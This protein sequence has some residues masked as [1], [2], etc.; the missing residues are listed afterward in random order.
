MS[1]VTAVKPED[2]YQIND[3]NLWYGEHHALKNINL[4]IPE[5]EIT[6]I[7]GPSGCGKSTFIKTLNL[8]INMVPNVK[9]TGEISY[10]GT[11]VLNSK[12]DLVELRKKVGMVFQ[13]GNPFPQSIFD[14]VAY[15]PR[16]HGLKNK[17][18]LNER[19]EK[20]LV[21]VALWDEVKD[22][23]HSQALGLSGG[24]QQ[25]LCIARALATNPDVLLMDEPTSALD[26]V[27]TLKIEELMLKLKEKYTIAI[28]THNMQQ[29]SRISDQTAFFLMGE[30]IECNDTV[31]MFSSPDDHRTK[32]YITGRFG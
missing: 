6:A 28:V 19:V 1:A 14:N 22:R 25:R 24:Q 3:L 2:V 9:M 18:E 15:G 7:I 31:K 26:P 10:N 13:K 30:L 23:L 12:V 4:T 5:Y 29:A 11:N 32:D 16:I 27:S 21:D 8:M 20:A 17:K